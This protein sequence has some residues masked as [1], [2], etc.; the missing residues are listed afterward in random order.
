MNRFSLT[1]RG[2]IAFTLSGLIVTSCVNADVLS[3][4]RISFADTLSMLHSVSTFS[5][6]V[7]MLGRSGTILHFAHD[8]LGNIYPPFTY[9]R[10]RWERLFISNP[11]GLMQR[12][13]VG[14]RM[15]GFNFLHNQPLNPTS[16][17][18][19]V[20]VDD[21]DRIIGWLYSRSLVGHEREAMP[22]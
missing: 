15:Y 11:Q 19:F 12:I 3:Y 9:G 20:C 18:L 6:F 5:E 2:G 7:E 21:N 17:Q 8:D 1:R 16:S 22:G 13:E 4:P 10:D 14:T